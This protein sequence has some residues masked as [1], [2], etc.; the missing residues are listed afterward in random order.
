[1]IGA[2]N[3]VGVNEGLRVGDADVVAVGDG[4]GSPE[5]AAVVNGVDSGVLSGVAVIDDEDMST[6]AAVGKVS[7]VAVVVDW[8]TTVEV[9][10][11]SDTPLE[12]CELPLPLSP[13]LPPDVLSTATYAMILAKTSA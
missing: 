9:A 8:N 13:P 11:P 6:V 3:T 5:R 10:A 4:V 12:D 2:H 7:G 1:M